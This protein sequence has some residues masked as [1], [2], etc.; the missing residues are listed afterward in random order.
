MSNT[1]RE[2]LD[3]ASVIFPSFKKGETGGFDF[4]TAPGSRSAHQFFQ[5]FSIECDS[6]SSYRLEFLDGRLLATSGRSGV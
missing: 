6:N 1:Y 3:V 4:F 5:S 2:S